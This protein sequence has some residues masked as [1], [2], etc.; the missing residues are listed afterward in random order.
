MHLGKGSKPV[1]SLKYEDRRVTP[2]V[3][4]ALVD[5]DLDNTPDI[6]KL[7]S[8]GAGGDR[9]KEVPRTHLE[10]NEI[11][12]VAIGD[13][14]RG[15]HPEFGSTYGKPFMVDTPNGPMEFR[16]P[17]DMGHFRSYNEIVNTLGLPNRVVN[18]PA[19]IGLEL[20]SSNRAKNALAKKG[21]PA[22][23]EE[24]AHLLIKRQQALKRD[25]LVRPTQ[26]TLHLEKLRDENPELNRLIDSMLYFD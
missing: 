16:L 7:G 21:L 24:I 17:Y 25:N 5:L 4:Q 11:M 18:A 8:G 12:Q 9:G 15:I 23:A 22:T 19:N 1:I 14:G 10:A 20:E 2:D 6:L 3:E 13:I 26:T